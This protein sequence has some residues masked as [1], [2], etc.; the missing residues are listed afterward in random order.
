MKSMSRFSLI[1]ESGVIS[2]VFSPYHQVLAWLL[3]TQCALATRVRESFARRLIDSF[4]PFLSTGHSRIYEDTSVA[5][6]AENSGLAPAK[7]LIA[8]PAWVATRVGVISLGIL[9][10]LM[11]FMGPCYLRLGLFIL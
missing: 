11:I 1:E 9:L 10:I 7:L 8:A 2:P 4:L 3:N 5:L 6:A